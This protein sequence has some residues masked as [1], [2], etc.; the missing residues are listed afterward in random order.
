MTKRNLAGEGV[1]LAVKLER[2]VVC[3]HGIWGGVACQEVR[4]DHRVVRGLTARHYRVQSS[5]HTQEVSRA[6]MLLHCR[7][8]G[9]RLEC[10]PRLVRGSELLEAE[11]WMRGEVVERLHVYCRFIP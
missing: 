1:R 2:A 5:A 8:A 7:Q 4:V 3:D 6:D 11:D 10:L 9:L